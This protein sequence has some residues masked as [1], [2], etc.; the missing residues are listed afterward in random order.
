MNKQDKSEICK[1]IETMLQASFGVD[2][3]V[4]CPENR[5]INLF[6]HPFNFDGI[7]LL[8]LLA[9]VEKKFRIKIAAKYLD[10]YSFNTIDGIADIIRRV[11]CENV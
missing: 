8:Y 11:I 3:I 2:P 6:L 7:A 4:L 5:K 10:D 9:E 1:E